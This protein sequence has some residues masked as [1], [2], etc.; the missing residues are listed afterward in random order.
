MD[1]LAQA[2]LEKKIFLS[3]FFWGAKIQPSFTLNVIFW[4]ENRHFIKV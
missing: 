4:A 2:C 1:G 3:E